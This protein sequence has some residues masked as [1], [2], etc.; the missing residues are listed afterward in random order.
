MYAVFAFVCVCVDCI[1]VFT[2]CSLFPREGPIPL[3][4]FL[5]S[6]KFLI[7]PLFA[8]HTQVLEEMKATMTFQEYIG[9]AA[10]KMPVC[11]RDV[12][13]FMSK[14]DAYLLL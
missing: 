5:T 4:I 9:N 13:L 1:Y 3:P 8:P 12:V 11:V 2:L 10:F 7:A 14:S 6:M